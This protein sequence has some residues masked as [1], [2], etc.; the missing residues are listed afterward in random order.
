MSV[1]IFIWTNSRQSDVNVIL[2]GIQQGAKR[3]HILFFFS[4]ISITWTINH[5]VFLKI[6]KLAKKGEKKS[7]LYKPLFI[8]IWQETELPTATPTLILWIRSLQQV[9]ILSP[10]QLSCLQILR[11]NEVAKRFLLPSL[12]SPHASL[13][14][15]AF[16]GRAWVSFIL[17]IF[18]FLALK[19]RQQ[20][21]VLHCH[22]SSMVIC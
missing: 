2:K 5:P 1:W 7:F 18:F 9:N 15:F 3:H 11:Q 17:L 22:G 20:H 19:L 4:P 8:K 6:I 13:S 10:I 21:F 12:P 14:H 16:P